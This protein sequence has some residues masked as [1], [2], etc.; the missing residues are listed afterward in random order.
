M[1]TKETKFKIKSISLTRSSIKRKIDFNQIKEV[2]LENE[3][4]KNTKKSHAEIQNIYIVY[5]NII[6]TA[7][8]LFNENNNTLWKDQFSKI[9]I[10][11]DLIKWDLDNK[12]YIPLTSVGRLILSKYKFW[13][14]GLAYLQSINTY[15]I[16]DFLQLILNSRNYKVDDDKKYNE[17][18]ILVI[19]R[20]FN[21]EEIR[22]LISKINNKSEESELNYSH[23]EILLKEMTSKLN[24]YLENK[25]I[26]ELKRSYSMSSIN[27]IK[28]HPYNFEKMKEYLVNIPKDILLKFKD[29]FEKIKDEKQNHESGSKKT[30]INKSNKDDNVSFVKIDK[31]IEV[32]NQISILIK[33]KISLKSPTE[34]DIKKL[35]DIE[36]DNV[37]IEQILDDG[38][39]MKLEYFINKVENS[40]KLKKI[41]INN[42]KIKERNL[43]KSKT[44]KN[45]NDSSKIKKLK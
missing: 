31:N 25:N 19:K 36:S 5:C 10:D 13:I 34:N 20:Y 30:Q 14:I 40:L 2:E 3:S 21:P 39:N 29:I 4:D 32:E 15:S 12:I 38:H 11:G 27:D 35:A 23:Y 26:K 45:K 9:I 22:N 8:I 43:S 42:N 7:F 33:K 6:D 41:K 16:Y 37:N 17:N 18:L 28:D 44:R 1:E 24:N